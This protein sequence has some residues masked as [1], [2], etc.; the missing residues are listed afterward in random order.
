MCVGYE[1][2]HQNPDKGKGEDKTFIDPDLHLNFNLSFIT[3]TGIT[4]CIRHFGD[5]QS[6]NQSKRKSTFA[7]YISEKKIMY[8]RLSFRLFWTE[9]NK[10]W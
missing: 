6:H 2:K 9:I 1:V 10:N 4:K 7:S 5:G 8:L 3:K